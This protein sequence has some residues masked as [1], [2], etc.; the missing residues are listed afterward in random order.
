VLPQTFSAPIPLP[1]VTPGDDIAD[2]GAHVDGGFD[3]YRS[4]YT[5]YDHADDQ[6]IQPAAVNPAREPESSVGLAVAVPD[7]ENG[8]TQEVRISFYPARL[9]SLLTDLQ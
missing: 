2:Y 4:N 3:G 8:D 7:S 6:F 5:G 9:W 1:P